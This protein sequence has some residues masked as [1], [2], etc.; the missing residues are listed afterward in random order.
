MSLIAALQGS[1]ETALTL[2]QEGIQLGERL[3]SPFVTA[4][5]Q[6]RLG[7]ALQIQAHQAAAR[8]WEGV[9][10]G[11]TGP[12]PAASRDE[13]IRGYRAA[14]ALGDALDVR[15]TRA[16]A[17]WGLT[18]AFGY[19]GGA[20]EGGGD[21]KA[22]E[23]A[24]REGLEIAHWAGDL[25]VGAL[26]EM[27]LGASYVLVDQPHEGLLALS[28]ATA[29]FR[30]C[31]DT[32]GRAAARLWE[33]LAH[34]ALKHQEAAL[35]ALH[36]ALGLCAVN[37]YDYLL[38]APTLLGPPDARR[39]VPLLLKARTHRLHTAYVGRLLALLDIPAVQAHA[40][41]RLHVQTLGAF[42]VWR[43]AAEVAPRDWQRDKARQLFQ[44]F[45]TER[46]RWLNRDEVV[47][48]LWPSLGP[49]AAVRD[50]KVALNALNRAVEPGHAP[51]EPFAF[52]AREGAAYRLRPDADL[53]LD[54]A[55]FE[56][57]CEAGLRG[58]LGGPEAEATLE[59]LRAGLRL[60]QGDYLPDALY[61]DWAT[62][63]RER[64][65]TLYLRAAD[66][67]ATALLERG[68]HEEALDVC[69]AILARDA[70]WERAYRIEMQA[71]ALLGNRPQALKSYQRCRTVL[72]AQL[73]VPPSPETVS[74]AA[75]LGLH[76]GR[77]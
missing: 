70:C 77:L 29:A 75:A 9:L 34:A 24:A 69:G 6:M 1:A 43:G 45:V 39:L 42:R 66:R 21:I 44:L 19:F 16:E 5:G 13:A 41:Y 28:R 40:G 8:G 50:F 53:W 64:M 4:V 61:E 59:H 32:F 18:R 36:E 46:G 2:A 31:G 63:T 47:E 48:R 56:R 7:H 52:V 30:D 20:G 49:E 25:W 60:Y 26:T 51:D 71:C 76:G 14:I 23:D 62:E 11:G 55:D 3:N 74:L 17:M 38:T 10:P 58:P 35:G 57:R 12:S 72:A 54:L 33:A 37:G 67:L 73:D 68:Q 65:L 27:T 22:A 15:R